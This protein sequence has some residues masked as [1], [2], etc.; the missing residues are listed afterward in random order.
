MSF[1]HKASDNFALSQGA[2]DSS[3][4]P[5]RSNSSRYHIDGLAYRNNREACWSY[6]CFMVADY[7]G[8]RGQ[9][10][11]FHLTRC[12]S[13]SRHTIIAPSTISSFWNTSLIIHK[14]GILSTTPA[15][16]GTPLFIHQLFVWS[17]WSA[18]STINPAVILR[19]ISRRKSFYRF[20]LL[21]TACDY[22]LPFYQFSILRG[23]LFFR[24]HCLGFW[25]STL[26]PK[27]KAL[28]I[29][30]PSRSKQACWSSFAWLL[31]GDFT[32]QE[33][34]AVERA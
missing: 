18:I 16:P 9:A 1:L 23:I 12:N 25:A 30:L 7:D 26:G 19:I 5:L 2:F 34:S 21:T 4:L 8:Y 33:S 20:L 6:I 3:L 15:V 24:N 28:L 14:F 22:E 31:L 11:G 32:S 13:L 29:Y 10:C 27:C 17:F